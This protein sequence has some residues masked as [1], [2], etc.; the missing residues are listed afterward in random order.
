MKLFTNRLFYVQG[1]EQQKLDIVANS[2]FINFLRNS[3]TCCFLVSEEMDNVVEV[4]PEK[5]VATTE[6]SQFFRSTSIEA[7][8][9]LV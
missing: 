6:I 5:Q 2:M 3:Y 4:E 8:T 1:E 7:S 9:N